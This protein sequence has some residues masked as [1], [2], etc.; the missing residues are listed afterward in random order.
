[1]ISVFRYGEWLFD[2]FCLKLCKNICC[3]GCKICKCNCC[4]LCCCWQCC[5]MAFSNNIDHINTNSNHLDA[6]PGVTLNV[7]MTQQT[8]TSSKNVNSNNLKTKDS[9]SL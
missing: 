4:Y 9:V 8:P 1:M 6:Q 7:Q 3:C 5:K 2:L